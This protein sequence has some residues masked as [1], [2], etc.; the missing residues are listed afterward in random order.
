MRFSKTSRFH[1]RSYIIWKE[2]S[3]ASEFM[4]RSSPSGGGSKSFGEMELLQLKDLTIHCRSEFSRRSDL[5]SVEVCKS[6]NWSKVSRRYINT[7]CRLVL[8]K[9]CYGQGHVVTLNTELLSHLLDWLVCARS[10]LRCKRTLLACLIGAWVIGVSAIASSQG[11]FGVWLIDMLHI[12][13]SK[14]MPILLNT[15]GDAKKGRQYTVL[16]VEFI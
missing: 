15:L 2:L 1:P 12:S 14:S 4:P 11:L 10:S 3:R 5:C 7:C 16:G 6:C 9:P 8:E 13:S